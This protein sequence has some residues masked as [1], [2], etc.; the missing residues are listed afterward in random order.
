MAVFTPKR[1]GAGSPG[2]VTPVQLTTSAAT[3][4]TTPVSTTTTIKQI[5]IT[6][7]TGTAAT[8]TLYLV[9]TGGTPAAANQIY[10]SVPVPGNTTIN[11][12]LTQ[13]LTAGDFIS[14]LAGTTTALNITISGIESV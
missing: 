1:L 5:L 3:I 4:Y 14:A 12:D 11:I 10:S 13:V 2:G 8:F 6:N 9:K 7:T